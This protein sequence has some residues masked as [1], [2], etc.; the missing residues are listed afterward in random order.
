MGRIIGFDP[1]LASTGW[2]VIDKI[3]GRLVHVAHGT[4]VTG[5]DQSHPGRLRAI[6]EQIQL[7]LGDFKPDA[8]SIES[9]FFARN[10]SSAFPVA[11]ARGVILLACALIDLPVYEFTPVQIK[12][13]VVG[14]GRADKNQVQQMVQL[15]LG[16]GDWKS[17]SHDADALAAAICRAHSENDNV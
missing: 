2:G 16:M 1:G 15:I 8:G 9:L 14:N 17:R 4:I 13:G 12:Q 7:I 3:R 11:E 10:T 6:F 5:T